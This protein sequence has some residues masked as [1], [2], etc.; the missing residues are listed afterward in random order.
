[1]VSVSMQRRLTTS[2]SPNVNARDF[3]APPST[4]QHAASSGDRE[5]YSKSYTRALREL[6]A[7]PPRPRAFTL[8]V[9]L[10]EGKA[11]MGDVDVGNCMFLE[12]HPREY[13][14][15][16]SYGRIGVGFRVPP[17]PATD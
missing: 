13:W 3:E 6:R 8:K 7:I 15:A 12:T 17:M 9:Y 5:R 2:S 4:I 10:M 1:M 16:S 14:E 11:E